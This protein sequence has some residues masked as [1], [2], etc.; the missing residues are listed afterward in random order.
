MIRSPLLET[1]DGRRFLAAQLMDS[2][3]AGISLVAISALADLG[4]ER[5]MSEVFRTYDTWNRRVP[6]PHLNRWLA[7]ALQRHAP[8]NQMTQR[9]NSGSR[10]K[11]RRRI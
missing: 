3:S 8:P 4:L 6:T 11:R 1:G 5:L 9:S 2:L 7:E 10:P